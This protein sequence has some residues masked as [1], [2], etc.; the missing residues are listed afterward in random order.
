VQPLFEFW[1]KSGREGEPAPMHSVP[2]HSLNVAACALVL[3]D[4]YPA[5]VPVPS[6][7]LA[8]LV[9]L[10]M[11]ATSLARFRRRFLPCGRPRSVHSLG[12]CRASMTMPNT[13]CFAVLICCLRTGR[14]SVLGFRYS[15]L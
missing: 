6:D 3:L 7:T 2:H 8:A 15:A 9:A 12:R 11:A 1:A 13:R 10:T 5:P 14:A 4:A